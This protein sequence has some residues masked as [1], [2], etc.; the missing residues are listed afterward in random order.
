M[1]VNNDGGTLA[2]AAPTWHIRARTG[3]LT[4]L[5]F[6]DEF[7]L[8]LVDGVIAWI[9]Y[10]G[11]EVPRPDVSGA[12]LMEYPTGTL[13]PGLID[14]HVHLTFSGHADTV[15][16]LHTE[17]EIGAT[18]R[19]LGNAQRALRHG[20]TTQVDCGSR[21]SI[22]LRLREALERDLAIGPR[23]L[24]AGAP[25]TTTA[26]HCHWLGGHA[27]SLDEVIRAARTRVAEGA[28]L[29]KIM[30]TG[31]NMTAGSNPSAL[32]YPSEVM[33]ALGAEAARLAKPLVVHAHSD[34]AVRLAALARARVIAHATCLR[35]GK[36]EL[37]EATLEAILESG[38][39]VDPT[40]M[41]GLPRE[42]ADERALARSKVREAMLP[43]YREMHKRGVP[44]LAG[45]DGGATNVE[46]HNV[47]GSVVAL[48]EEVGLSI[49]AALLA[50][51]DLPARAF[52]LRDEVGALEVGLAADVVVVD[53][54]LHSHLR[55]L[56]DP[57]A[58]WSRGRL[59]HGSGQ[60]HAGVLR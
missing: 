25:L 24:S 20:V 37:S 55:A 33:L 57:S 5:G 19:A 13:L 11:S 22:V 8:L 58:V 32:Q 21:G 14:P 36:Y 38:A 1:S 43:I 47:A 16:I 28:D 59:V 26:G 56:A 49:E 4:D 12:V 53:A 6:V 30:L 2:A 44:L 39:Y 7:E 51:T 15:D 52:G 23:I 40:L 9:G 54:D 10:A 46:H 3:F 34:E 18:V 29:V 48:H 31:G 42:G 45:T 41:V 60:K 50:A 35:D 27:D 17:D